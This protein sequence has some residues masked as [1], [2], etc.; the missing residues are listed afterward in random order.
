M[1]NW[2]K[3]SVIIPVMMAAILLMSAPMSALADADDDTEASTGSTVRGVLAIVAPLKARVN[4]EISMRV[5]LREDQEPLEGAGIWAL[6]KD[7]AEVMR[8]EL[9]TLNSDTSIPAED[10][11]YEALA[12]IHGTFIG[13]TSED[14]RLY[15]AFE[16][17]NTYVLAAV[18]RTYLPGFSTIRVGE[19]IK[20]LTLKAPDKALPGEEVLMT[21]YQRGTVD[22]IDNAGIWAITRENAEAM[23]DELTALREDTSIP[24]EEKDYQSIIDSYGTFLGRTDEYGNF[25]Y[26]FEI[27]GGYLLAAV[28][29]GYIPGFSPIRIGN[30]VVQLPAL[31][32]WAPLRALAGSEVT[33]T[34]Y[35]RGTVDAIDNAGIWAITRGEAEMLKE[36]IGAMKADSS[37]GS[38][39]KDYEALVNMYGFY[40]GQ[41]D[42][43]GQLTNVFEEEGDYILVSVKRGYIPGFS[44]IRIVTLP[45]TVTPRQSDSTDTAQNLSAK[46]NQTQGMKADTLRQKGV[47]GKGVDNAAGLKKT[48]KVTPKTRNANQQ[49][50]AKV[51]PQRQN[52]SLNNTQ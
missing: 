51:R 35:Q 4:Q 11:D 20:A 24:G 41:T 49:N 6:T 9:A 48:T 26:V 38:E 43:Y 18:K 22:T 52:T 33:M 32:I 30:P 36:Q 7:Q 2:K 21:V 47:Q 37:L 15:H 19:G 45:L 23:R 46:N 5:F 25:S 39:E 31:T 34:V 44:P 16:E 3:W 10:K 28:Q 8:E 17:A 12:D 13:H 50:M 29:R 27:E 42:E 14:G 1:K 40:I